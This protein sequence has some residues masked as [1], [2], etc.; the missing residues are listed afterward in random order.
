MD[1]E[2]LRA[3]GR[4]PVRIVEPDRQDP[5]TRVSRIAIIVDGNTVMDSQVTLRQGDLPTMDELKASLQTAAKGQFQP[6]QMPTV[7]LL[8][9]ALL[10]ANM[11]G[12][13]RDAV[14]TVITRSNGGCNIDLDYP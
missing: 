6:W 3:N 14:I 4:K 11:K 1:L 2:Q 9:A 5:G 12:A 7:G 8:S 13:I 10:E